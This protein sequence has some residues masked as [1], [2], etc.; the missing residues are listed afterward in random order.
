MK[1]TRISVSG[2]FGQ[3][4]YDFG[5]N[6]KERITIMIG[7]NGYGKTTILRLINVI[8]NGPIQA[9]KNFHF[10]KLC[11]YF[12][13]PSQ[14]IIVRERDIEEIIDVVIT[15]NEDDGRYES[16]NVNSISYSNLRLPK[17]IIEEI[18]PNLNQ[19]DNDTWYDEESD[20][21]LN[22]DT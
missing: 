22:N 13:K 8:F 20:E 16:F 10:K 18:V 1:I 19:I 21:I 17:M 6:H 4:D 2:L 14:L 15:Y 7:P 3:F 12:D 5:L 11:V 9:L